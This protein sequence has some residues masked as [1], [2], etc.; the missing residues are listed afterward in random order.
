MKQFI[1][2]DGCGATLNADGMCPACGFHP[3]MQ[4]CKLVKRVP[5]PA[6][7]V[8][9]MVADLLSTLRKNPGVRDA[10]FAALYPGGPADPRPIEARARALEAKLAGLEQVVESALLW[11]QLEVASE[12]APSAQASRILRRDADR[13]LVC[14]RRMLD[15]HKTS[16]GSG[17]DEPTAAPKL[18]QPEPAG[19]S[20][21]EPLCWCGKPS[22]V[23]AP[24]W[25]G[26]C[27]PLTDEQTAALAAH[28]RA[29][30]TRTEVKTMIAEAVA[31][32][33]DRVLDIVIAACAD[34]CDIDALDKLGDGLRRAAQEQ[35]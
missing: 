20:K 29:G 19:D 16:A 7:S 17:A 5:L 21:G 11:R 31:Y 13:K 1:H 22:R 4:S 35:K 8:T 28:V 27:D 14:L 25:C 32:A 18:E 24:S 23:A 26:E 12:R 30:I 6:Y 9:S 2:D 34:L 10:V 33:V 3:D 15:A